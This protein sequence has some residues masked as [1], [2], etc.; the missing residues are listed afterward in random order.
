M[1]GEL[2]LIWKKGARR[3]GNRL[4]QMISILWSGAYGDSRFSQMLAPHALISSAFVLLAN[5]RSVG[6]ID[7]SQ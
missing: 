5:R 3:P 7:T 4:D 1:Q 6:A 2:S